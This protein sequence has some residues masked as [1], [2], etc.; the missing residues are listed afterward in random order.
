MIAQGGAAALQAEKDL[1]GAVKRSINGLKKCNWWDAAASPPCYC[2]LAAGYSGDRTTGLFRCKKH[3]GNAEQLIKSRG[4]DRSTRCLFPGCDGTN[5]RPMR[6]LRGYN[7]C[8]STQKGCI[9]RAL[10]YEAEHGKKPEGVP[11]A[12]FYR[13]STS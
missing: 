1:R 10:D 2:D 13:P 8:G 4:D 6:N 11:W 3:G 9:K 5:G 12:E 7:F